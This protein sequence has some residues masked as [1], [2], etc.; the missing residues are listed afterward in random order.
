MPMIEIQHISKWY[1]DFQV[2]T[3]CTTSIEKGEVVVVCGPSGSGKSTLIKT[4]NA[5]EP[6]QEGNIV[7][8]G[9][10]LKDSKTDLAKFRSRVGMVFQH[11]ELFPHM[12]V[13]DNL[14]I[15]QLKVLN[16]SKAEAEKKAL[17]YLDRVGLAA[18]KNKF[19]GQLSGGQQQRVAI[20]RGL[21][22]DPV[23]MLFDEPTSALDPEMVG[24]VLEVMSQL[25]KEGMTMMCVTH[26]MGFARKVSSRVIFMDQGKILEDCA[27]DDFFN[28]PDERHERTKFFLDKISMV[29]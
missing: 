17:Q 29:H 27:T 19:P 5:L 15:G 22:M 18:H 9:T 12:T 10:A 11:F 6:F 14:T 8:D 4:V 25:A 20:A 24:E 2:L 26:E 28:K 16:R 23:C 7:V 21:C 3:D 13:L 1:G